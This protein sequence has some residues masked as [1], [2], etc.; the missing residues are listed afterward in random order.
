M[1]TIPFAARTCSPLVV[2]GAFLLSPASHAATIAVTTCDDSGPGSLRA[3]V[4]GAASGDTVDLRGLGCPR[5]TLTSGP[6]AIPQAQLNIRGAGFNRLA[7]SGNWQSSVF[8]HDVAGGVLRIRGIAVEHGVHVATQAR[9]GCIYTAGRAELTDVHVRH[10]RVD[11]PLGPGHAGGGVYAG[12]GLKLLYSA[13]YSNR[14]AGTGGGAYVAGP[15]RAH[16][17]RF[18]K[19]RAS[20]GAGFASQGPAVVSYATFAENAT[21]SSGGGAIS[22]ASTSTPYAVQLFHSTVAGNSSPSTAGGVLGQG[23]I[24]V[25]NSTFSGNSAGNSPAIRT[26]GVISAYNSTFAHHVVTGSL[27]NSVFAA[28]DHWVEFMS[29]IV[30]YTQ[31]PQFESDC[32]ELDGA[33]MA[34]NSMATTLGEDGWLPGVTVADPKLGP[35]QANGGRTQTHALLP[36]SPAI[37]TGSNPLALTTDQRGAGFPR[38]IGAATDIG[39]FETAADE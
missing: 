6:I 23:H 27:Y 26:I 12:Q 34:E 14:A 9:G 18:V 1:I 5:I 8:R 39:A 33:T 28:M 36:D 32:I 31:C 38:T 21:S 3:A 4:A 7:V 24:L 17:V 15:V 13:L 11:G 37:D 30:A 20:G 16:R 29:S 10:C 2:V 22:A 35:L 25:V 19:N